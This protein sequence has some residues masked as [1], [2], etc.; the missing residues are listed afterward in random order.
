M[1]EMPRNAT[2]QSARG[3]IIQE[4]IKYRNVYS[5]GSGCLHACMVLHV[6]DAGEEEAACR[7]NGGLRASNLFA[8]LHWVT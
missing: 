1:S 7:A 8:G 2:P 5:H 4:L 6:E 3:I